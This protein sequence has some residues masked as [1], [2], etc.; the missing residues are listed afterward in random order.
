MAGVLEGLRIVEGSAFVAAPL[1]GM[2][3]AQLGADV[4]RFDAVR[5]GID[6]A[7]WPVAPDGTSLFWRGMNK[8]KRSIAVDLRRPEGRELVTALI[9]APGPDAGLFLTNFPAAGWLSYE[10]LSAGRDDLIM[11]SLTGNPDGSTAVD[12]TINPATGFPAVTGDGARPVNHVLP[13]WDVAP[14]LTLAA[15]LPAPDRHPGRT[16]QG[17]HVTVSLADVAF[18]VMGD[19]GYLAQA[20]VGGGRPALGNDLYGAFRRGLTTADGRR[21]MVVAIT[22]GQSPALRARPPRP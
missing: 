12:Y 4:I 2:T 8:G 7:R 21:I 9:A 19:L 3:L 5:G 10:R 13:A 11:L 14:A 15:G 16:G 22:A 1:G 6:H 18:A 20:Q 17:R